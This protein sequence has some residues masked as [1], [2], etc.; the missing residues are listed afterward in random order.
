M[1]TNIL[2]IL[3]ILLLFL[4][5][6]KINLIDKLKNQPT[7]IKNIRND[8][9]QIKNYILFSDNIILNKENKD[10]LI[11]FNTNKIYSSKESETINKKDIFLCLNTSSDLSEEDNNL[12]IK[13]AF[14]HEYSHVISVEYGH[15]KEFWDN[16]YILL[17]IASK[18]NIINLSRLYYLFKINSQYCAHKLSMD[19]LP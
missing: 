6:Y 5:I 11:K 17:N 2:I 14:L 16:F 10:L 19:Y 3:L 1:L 8:A 15:G 13:F 18:L 4:Y 7:I 9:L 12:L